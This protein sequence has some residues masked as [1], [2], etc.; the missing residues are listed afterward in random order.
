MAVRKKR[1]VVS[2]SRVEKIPGLKIVLPSGISAR[3]KKRAVT[4]GKKEL[5]KEKII[6]L[7]KLRT[8]L[9]ELEA[10]VAK[11]VKGRT[12]QLSKES[13][14]QT[15]YSVTGN[16]RQIKITKRLSRGK[17]ITPVTDA[18]EFVYVLKK[19]AR[20]LRILKNSPSEIHPL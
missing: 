16:G 10:L 2:T 18:G 3:T 19:A 1:R 15:Q 13:N 5:E 14:R 9:S 20:E 8:D 17:P 11:F 4:L 12:L 6:Q 7:A